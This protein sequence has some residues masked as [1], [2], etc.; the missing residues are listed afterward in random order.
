M[1][2]RVQFYSVF[3]FSFRTFNRK[4][5]F[6][7][8]LL[9]IGQSNTSNTT[10]IPE[11]DDIMYNHITTYMCLLMLTYVYQRRSL[12]FQ[13]LRDHLLNLSQTN[14]KSIFRYQQLLSRTLSKW[15]HMR[16]WGLWL[17]L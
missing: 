12:D 8:I 3:F 13:L 7:L 15:W 2:L 9:N 5:T 14:Y 10:V 4:L 16:R 6:S 17:H 11:I 1:F